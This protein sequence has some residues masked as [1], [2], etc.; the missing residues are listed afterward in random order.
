MI[1]R[2]SG[3]QD[4]RGELGDDVADGVILAHIDRTLHRHGK[5][6][7]SVPGACRPEPAT[8]GPKCNAGVQFSGPCPI[9]HHQQIQWAH[10][11]ASPD[12]ALTW[13]LFSALPHPSLVEERQT[14]CIGSREDDRLMHVVPH[15]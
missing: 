5:V 14:I 2:A 4:L 8:V 1:N 9:R 15:H 10:C 7:R 11:E 3:G 6:A 12:P 13:Q